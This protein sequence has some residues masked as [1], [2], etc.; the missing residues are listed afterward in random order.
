MVCGRHITVL[1]VC[2]IALAPWL[3]AP[4]AK[5]LAAGQ[6]AT[7]TANPAP[8]PEQLRALTARAIE[9][10]HRDDRA[11]DEYERIERAI[12]RKSENTEIVTDITNRY[13]PSATGNIKL[14]LAENGNAVSPE[15]YRQE[16]EY[17]VNALGLPAHPT[18]RY[19]EDLAKYQKRVHDH[20]ELVDDAGRA[21]RVTW[22]GRETRADSTAPHGQRTLMKFLLDPDPAFKPVNR[23]AVIFQ[24]IHATLWV[25]EEQVQFAR[26][27]AD[28]TTDIPFAGGVVGKVYRG[29]H[30]AMQQEEV[31]PGIWLPTLFSYNLDGRKFLFAFG[32]HERTEISRYRRIGPPSEALG[33]IRNELNTLAAAAS[34]R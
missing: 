24:H 19:K 10:Q 22:A 3:G 12:T 13:V 11:L 23:F 7:V 6:G 30:I 17:A 2:L 21:F 29:G 31:A 9:N 16:L 4:L 33:I 34:S 18:D 27:E 25:D 5:A 15:L 28:V 20:T 8:T 14:K 1:G 32:V 26:L